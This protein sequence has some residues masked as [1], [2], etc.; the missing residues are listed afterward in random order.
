MS[1]VW[2]F[3]IKSWLQD[4]GL[5]GYAEAFE[6]PFVDEDVLPK[7]TAEDLTAMGVAAIGDRRRLLDAIGKEK[8]RRP[9]ESGSAR[10]SPSAVSEL[11]RHQERSRPLQHHWERSR[12]SRPRQRHRERS[13]EPRSAAPERSRFR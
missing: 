4:L 5:G 12:D 13:P 11:Y 1:G 3:S 10:A 6:T 8:L 9:R 7:L 2:R